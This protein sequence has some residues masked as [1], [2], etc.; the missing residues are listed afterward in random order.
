V[1]GAGIPLAWAHLGRILIVVRTLR[2]YLV[3]ALVLITLAIASPVLAADDADE[4]ESES[5]R[6]RPTYE[7]RPPP[8]KDVYTTDYLFA[9]T[10]AVSES[11]LVPAA[12]VPLYILTV[13]LDIAFLPMEAIAG[14]FPRESN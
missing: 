12:Q 2:L 6:L 3:R 13:P 10:R 4:E 8:E 5:G 9:I 1:L 11:T 7:P 14:F